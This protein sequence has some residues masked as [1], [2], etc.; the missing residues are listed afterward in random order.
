V[1][2]VNRSRRG[3]RRHRQARDVG[4]AAVRWR[5]LDTPA[6][7]AEILFKNRRSQR[8]AATRTRSLVAPRRGRGRKGLSR[9]H[10]VSP[11]PSV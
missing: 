1:I 3:E 9:S 11:M 5:E 4:S 10:S 6:R 2:D 7:L 8:R